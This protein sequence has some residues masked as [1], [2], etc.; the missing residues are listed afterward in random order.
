M[1][2]NRTLSNK[3][4]FLAEAVFEPYI[5]EAEHLPTHSLHVAWDVQ[6]LYVMA[7]IL[8][9]WTTYRVSLHELCCLRESRRLE[10]QQMARDP[11]P[12]SAFS[13]ASR[14]EKFVWGS[15]FLERHR[16]Y[17]RSSQEP[18]R[19]SRRRRRRQRTRSARRCVRYVSCLSPTIPRVASSHTRRVVRSFSLSI[20]RDPSICATH[21]QQLLTRTQP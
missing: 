13:P 12:R 5:R 16:L 8:T 3:I 2:P 14:I 15:E 4:A 19:R 18:R 11:K 7:P 9:L 17:S 6:T 10:P 21:Q 1:L 20:C